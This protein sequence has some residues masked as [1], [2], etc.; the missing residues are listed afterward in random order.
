MLKFCPIN[1]PLSRRM[2][3]GAVCLAALFIF[4]GH[5]IGAVAFLAL[6]LSRFWILS[7]IYACWIIY[8]RETPSK[9]GRRSNW[10]RRLKVWQHLRDYFPVTLV[11]TAELDPK[12]NY[13]LGYHP[14]GIIGAGAFVNFATEGS[15]FSKLFP[16]ITPRVLTLKCMHYNFIHCINDD[17]FIYL[18]IFSKVVMTLCFLKEMLYSP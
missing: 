5:T 17:S 7:V 6:F 16:G 9:G 10:F 13:I 3:T 4:L 11:K 1:I 14:H 12:R 2:Q 8:D 15:N 18:K